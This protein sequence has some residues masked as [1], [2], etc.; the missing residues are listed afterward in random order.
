MKI[1]LGGID[2]IL[3]GSSLL[4]SLKNRGRNENILDFAAAGTTKMCV[5]RRIGVD[6]YFLFIDGKNLY[7]PRLRKNL[8]SAVDSGVGDGGKIF[9]QLLVG[10]FCRGM[11]FASVKQFE[12]ADSLGGYL[13]AFVA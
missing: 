13:E 3:R 4:K 5:G 10:D 9:F 11:I 6:K 12:D 2:G 7:E 1:D 8:G